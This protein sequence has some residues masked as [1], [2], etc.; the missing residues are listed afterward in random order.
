MTALGR[1]ETLPAAMHSRDSVIDKHAQGIIETCS[2]RNLSVRAGLLVFEVVATSYRGD[3]HPTI[4]LKWFSIHHRIQRL[5]VRNEE[6]FQETYLLM[7]KQEVACQCPT[8]LPASACMQAVAFAET[9]S[10]FLRWHCHKQLS[11]WAWHNKM[12]TL[13]P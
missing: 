1:V 4:P 5:E 8:S 3:M 6:R 10:G 7:R 9:S 2:E 11:E 13:C 12:A